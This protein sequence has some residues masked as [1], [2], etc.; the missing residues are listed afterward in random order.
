MTKFTDIWRTYGFIAN[1]LGHSPSRLRIYIFNKLMTK[2]SFY[3]HYVD[4]IVLAI[5][6]TLMTF[7]ICLTITET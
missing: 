2:P 6:K 1:N 7:V 5:D 4:D 3:V